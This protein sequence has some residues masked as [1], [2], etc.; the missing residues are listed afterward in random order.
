MARLFSQEIR[1]PYQTPMLSKCTRDQ[2]ILF[3]IGYAWIGHRGARE[4]LELMFSEHQVPLCI[5]SRCDRL[6]DSVA[7]CEGEKI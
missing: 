3:C 7:R 2:A 5:P 4:L 1:K 6:S